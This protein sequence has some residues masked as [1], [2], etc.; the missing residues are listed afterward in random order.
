[1]SYPD[2]QYSSSNTMFDLSN[3][4]SVYDLVKD[5]IRNIS[6]RVDQL[7][8]G[9]AKIDQKS[10]NETMSSLD[11]MQ[12]KVDSKLDDFKKNA[13]WKH[14]TIAF[15]GETNA[16]KSTLIEALRIM[17]GEEVRLKQQQ[18]YA[19]LAKKLNIDADEYYRI[20]SEIK[21]VNE[22]ISHLTQQRLDIDDKYSM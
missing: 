9:A 14:F 6:N 2:S 1:M 19:S 11:S 17:L 3:P 20:Q 16:G 8:N 15:F 10:H 22:N 21:D 7:N 4:S 18:K 5:Q 12:Q 13:E